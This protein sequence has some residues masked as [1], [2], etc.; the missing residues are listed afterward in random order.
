[1]LPNIKL[2]GK[3]G[4]IRPLCRLLVAIVRLNGGLN[5]AL[6]QFLQLGK[7]PVPPAV[8]LSFNV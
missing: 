4:K 7:V 3:G 6:V 8:R 5:E 2:S 1:M